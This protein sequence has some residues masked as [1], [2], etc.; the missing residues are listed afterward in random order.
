A[1]SAALTV[2]VDT[3]APGAPTIGAFS[4]DSGT[5]GDGITSDNTL[6]L[7]G[8][9]IANSTVKLFDGST[10]IGTTTADASGNWN[11][12]TATLAD[13]NHNFV[14]K[15]EDVAGNLSAASAA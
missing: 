14:A 6:T 1:A 5:L 9:A 2:T 7:T 15:T 3:S 13:G 8:S 10:Q 11:F 4:T 12:A